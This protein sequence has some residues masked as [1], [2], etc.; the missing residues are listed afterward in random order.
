MKK[1]VFVVHKSK[2]NRVE[3]FK[4]KIIACKKL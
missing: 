4:R 1:I 3:Y 2:K